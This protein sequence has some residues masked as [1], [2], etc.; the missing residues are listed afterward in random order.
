M[1]SINKQLLG[2]ET[3]ERLRSNGVGSII[4]ALSAN[5]L[6]RDFLNAGADDFNLKPLPCKAD[7]LK[8][9]LHKLITTRPYVVSKSKPD[10]GLA[11]QSCPLQSSQPPYSP[12]DSMLRKD[13][14]EPYCV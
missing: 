12:F 10:E 6:R 8:P 2:T 4:C 1:A 9:L 3:I 7:S 11:S 5:N 13:H 14:E